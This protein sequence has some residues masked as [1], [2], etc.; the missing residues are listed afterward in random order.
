MSNLVELLVGREL[1]FDLREAVK[2][3][4]ECDSSSICAAGSRSGTVTV[5]SEGSLPCYLN[6]QPL[7]LKNR[8]EA[9]LQGLWLSASGD[10]LYAATSIDLLAVNTS[11]RQVAW[12]YQQRRQWGFLASIPQGGYLAE[13]DILNLLYSSGEEIQIDRHSR[14]LRQSDS[15]YSPRL[16]AKAAGSPYV[17]GS[18]GHVIWR[19]GAD[20]GFESRRI[21][22]R[23]PCYSIALSGDGSRLAVRSLNEVSVYEPESMEVAGRF[24]VEPGL[25]QLALDQH[26]SWVAHMTNARVVFRDMAGEV[27]GMYDA[28]G[29]FPI[30]VHASRSGTLVTGLRSGSAYS[31]NWPG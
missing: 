12:H 22:L 5:W 4:A 3:Y 28:G 23:K 15:G 13:G 30:S 2:F 19:W 24:L 7:K 10:I 18:D 21:M 9:E 27:G 26:G 14:I 8:N 29:D 1:P 11:T 16:V 17:F 6:L 20:D 31:L 25:P